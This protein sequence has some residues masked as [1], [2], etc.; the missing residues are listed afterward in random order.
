MNNKINY[1][2]DP[3][4][5]FGINK[6][7]NRNSTWIQINC[8]LFQQKNHTEFFPWEELKKI[9]HFCIKNGLI[10]QFF[11]I[12]K[13]PG[14]RMRFYGE[15]LYT[16]FIPLIVEWLEENENN[17][18]IRGYKFSIYEPE[19]YRFGGQGGIEVAHEH[20]S[21][22]S[23]III[24]YELAS[25]KLKKSLPKILL[26]IISMHHLFTVCNNDKAEVWETWKKLQELIENYIIISAQNSIDVLGMDVE[27]QINLQNSFEL[28]SQEI[29]INF[30]FIKEKNSHISKQIL[31]IKKNNLTISNLLQ[32]N[33]KSNT[34]NIGSREWL[35][36]IAIFHWNRFGFNI[37]D[38]KFIIE[39]VLT[40]LQ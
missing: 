16:K 1:N 28:I 26:S 23:D 15:N 3:L 19:I 25:G 39:K 30:D 2:L 9:V 34:I 17:N 8:S 29:D 6:D 37:L 20:F 10:K 7:Y 18:N 22:D 24:S 36:S 4:N 35:T 38:I 14:I 27:N 40:N 5:L 11:F 32:T 31:K 12:K 13:P 33:L 21:L